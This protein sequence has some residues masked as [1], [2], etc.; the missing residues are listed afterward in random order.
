MLVDLPA[1]RSLVEQPIRWVSGR[2]A[3]LVGQRAGRQAHEFLVDVALDGRPQ[4]GELL[5]QGHYRS[6]C[7]CKIERV[8][9]NADVIVEEPGIS[10]WHVLKATRDD[11]KAFY[12][13]WP[14]VGLP[15]PP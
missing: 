10:N 11:G 14:G 13:F 3:R 6:R 12:R 7:R 15:V 2:Q 8:Y 1:G 4:P 9:G 5:E